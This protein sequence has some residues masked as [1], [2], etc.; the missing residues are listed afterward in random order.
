MANVTG[1][2]LRELRERADVGLRA[3]ARKTNSRVRLSDS[4]L[5]RVE[6]GERPVTPAVL[7][8]YERALGM[9][10]NDDVAHDMTT[11]RSYQDREWDEFQATIVVVAGGGRPSMQRDGRLLETGAVGAATPPRIETSDVAQVE[12]AA[13]FVRSLD[14]R[15]GGELAG[16]M[17][18]QLLRSGYELLGAQSTDAV[19]RQLDVAIGSLAAWAGWSACDSHR[20]AA[21]RALLGLALNAAVRADEP[22]LRAHILVDIAA[23]RNYLGHRDDAVR[24]LRLADGDERIGPAIQSMVH[25]G[26]ARVYGALGDR[27][28]CERAV[29]LVEEAARHV[30]PCTVPAWLGGWEFAHVQGMCG[31]AYSQLAQATGDSMDLAEAHKRLTSAADDLST[32]RP[33]TAALCHTS[34]SWA[35]LRCGNRDEA[36]AWLR[37]AVRLASELRSARV[38]RETTSIEQAIEGP[39]T[40]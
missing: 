23:L 28:R 10:I 34:L 24:I 33:R 29:Q 6:R 20:F 13:L 16:R 4:H 18:Y 1:Q 3:I 14:L 26:R 5:S 30:E 37:H 38:S 19:G 36:E 32:A 27:N 40:P 35:H 8:A 39:T 12:Q 11:Q 15:H 9:I 7:A 22:D 17:A 21:A 2:M 25:G 31:Q